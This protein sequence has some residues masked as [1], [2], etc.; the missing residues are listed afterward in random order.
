MTLKDF[1]RIVEI[2]TKI[3]SVSALTIAGCYTLWRNG[4]LPFVNTVLFALA[5]VAVDMATTGFNT[6]FDFVH[7]VD[8]RETN[9]ENDKVLVHEKIGGVEVLVVSLLLCVIAAGIGIILAWRVSGWVIVVGSAGMAVGFLYNAGPRPISSTPWGE[10]FS[11]GALGWSLITLGVYILRGG[12]LAPSE[13][14]IGIPSSFIVS[15]I[16]SVNNACDMVGDRAAGRKTLAILIGPRWA[17]RIIPLWALLSCV[18]VGVLSI[19]GVL[20][21]TVAGGVA[22]AF[23]AAIPTYRSMYRGGFSHATKG[24]SMRAISRIFL[25]YTIGYTVPLLVHAVRL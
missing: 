25:L 5:T 8:R 2:R 17:R 9:R 12:V 22:V 19:K 21:P 1:L 24:R 11:G 6:F 4:T 23:L 10:F 15:S 7:G 3:V 16:L 14:L 20:P 13:A 18:T